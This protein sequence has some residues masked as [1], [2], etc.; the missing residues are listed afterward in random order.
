MPRLPLGHLEVA[1][2]DPKAYRKK[3]DAVRDSG[4]GQ[5]YFNYLRIALLKYH[6]SKDR[7]AARRYLEEK[8]ERFKSAWRQSETLEQFEWYIEE[9]TRRRWPTFET[10]L[11]VRVLLPEWVTA[12]LYCSG[13]I[14]RV[15]LIPTGGYAA[16]L[17]KSREPEGWEEQLQMP[18]IQD[19]VAQLLNVPID[20]VQVGLYAF[21]EM[22]VAS[23]VYTR[24]E[25]DRS[26]TVLA[27]LLREM[28]Y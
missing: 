13:E 28:G 20:E 16:W 24:R 19:T 23:R 6:D 2:K 7:V 4:F 10:R 12:D 25:I 1:L 3:L 11:R 17:F 8:L 9:H 5:S 22:S 15:D 21:Q 14:P 27:N 26:H 18:L